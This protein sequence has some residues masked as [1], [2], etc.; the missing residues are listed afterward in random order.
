MTMHIKKSLQNQ[1]I[2]LVDALDEEFLPPLRI[3]TWQDTAVNITVGVIVG[4]SLMMALRWCDNPPPPPKTD[5][6]GCHRKTAYTEYFKRAG[7]RSP[8]EMAEAVLASKRNTRLLAAIAKVE[9]GGNSHVRDTGY[10]NRHS[11]AFQVAAKYHGAVPFDAASQAAQAEAILEELVAEKKSI[12]MALNQ[13]GGDST[14]RYSQKVLR[15]LV[16]VP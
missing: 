4:V 3:N 9:S 11:G 6:A 10:K 2:N 1:K 15:E 5:C 8:Q 16:N 14:D 12:R 7:S 13:Y